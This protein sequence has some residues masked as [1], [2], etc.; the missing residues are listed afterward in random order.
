MKRTIV[1]LM[2][3]TLMLFY[4]SI[5][6]A[7]EDTVLLLVATASSVYT[8]YCSPDKAV[9]SNES[10]YWIGG[11]NKPPWWIIFDTGAVNYITKMNMK[12]LHQYYMPQ[13]YDIQI[14]SNGV[15][16]KNVY[17]GI[18]DMYSAQGDTKDVNRSARYVRLYIKSVQFYFPVLKEVNIYGSK[19]VVS[20]LMRFQA[21]LNDTS[22]LPIEGAFTLTFRIYDQ[23]TA[24]ATLWHETQGDIN[25]EE[26]LLNVELGSVTSLNALSF[27]RQYWLSIQVGFDSEITPRFKLTGMPYSFTLQ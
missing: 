17:S 26:G 14:S 12:W 27:D 24:G 8:P 10:T 23:E 22:G 15:T 5:S 20:R 2:I 4:F 21:G 19:P 1:F 11:M 6:M 13:N 25:I 16:W 9:D 7:A 18:W 3:L